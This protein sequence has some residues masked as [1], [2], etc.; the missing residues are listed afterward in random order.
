MVSGT[1]CASSQEIVVHLRSGSKDGALA[2]GNLPADGL[3][4]PPS[5]AGRTE[6]RPFAVDVTLVIAALAFAAGLSMT[7][8]SLAPL[9]HAADL[10]LSPHAAQG[11]P[12]PATS[13]EGV[14]GLTPSQA[15]FRSVDRV[16]AG[17][18]ADFPPTARNGPAI[19]P[20][21]PRNG[22]TLWDRIRVSSK[23]DQR[24]FLL[25]TAIQLH[26]PAIAATPGPQFAPSAMLPA[27]VGGQDFS[28]APAGSRAD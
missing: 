20:L 27:S 26:T 19:S 1:P 28:E 22:V 23:H 7:A 6:I 10:A 3:A 24:A 2:R 8:A 9:D 25:G 16:G 21:F 17:Q 11:S 12:E 5:S 13:R 15:S 18:S 4:H 14:P